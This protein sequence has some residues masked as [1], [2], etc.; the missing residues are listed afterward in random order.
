MTSVL[1][2]ILLGGGDEFRDV[3]DAHHDSFVVSSD[4][5]T[6]NSAK[7]AVRYPVPDPTSRTLAPGLS[8]SSSM[9]SAY[10][11]MCGAEMV[12]PY[13]MVCGES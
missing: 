10:A 12:A 8:R 3:V 11:C 4:A 1:S 13:P 2:R 6:V 5:A 7:S 9:E